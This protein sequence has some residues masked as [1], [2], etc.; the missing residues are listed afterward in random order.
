MS[1]PERRISEHLAK[2]VLQNSAVLVVGDF[3]RRIDSR[4]CAEVD[5]Q[6]LR[7]ARGDFDLAARNECVGQALDVENF[8]ARQSERF[9]IFARQKFERQHAHADQIAAMNALETFGEHGA[10]AEK[11]RPLGGPIAR[12]AGAIFFSGDHDQRRFFVA[13][14]HGRVV[15]GHFFAAGL[16][17]RPAAF[18]AGSELIAQANVGERAAHHHFVIAATRAVGIEILGLNAERNQIFSRGAVGGKRAGGRNVIGGD[19]IAEHG[20]RAQPLQ[21]SKRAGLFAACCRN[22]ADS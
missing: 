7:A 5:R 6:S 14:F 21:I 19:A 4:R 22:T 9:Q 11:D 16:M 18:G 20:E 10:D 15:D 13:V 1:S 3:K 17:D 12:G 8:Q 2:D